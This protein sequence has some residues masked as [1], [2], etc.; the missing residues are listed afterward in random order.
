M[1]G[2]VG[3]TIEH[4]L[5]DLFD[6]NP[7]TPDGAQWHVLAPVAGGIDEHHLDEGVEVRRHP[8]GLPA[9]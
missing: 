1:H 9:R 8:I 7:L 2:G 6:E 5:L 3:P 4:G